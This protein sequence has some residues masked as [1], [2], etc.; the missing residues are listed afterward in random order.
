MRVLVID[1]DPI[2]IYLWRRRFKDA[3]I[4]WD[5]T[6][7]SG[8]LNVKS[9]PDYFDHVFIDYMGTHMQSTVTKAIKKYELEHDNIIIMSN[10]IMPRNDVNYKFMLKDEVLEWMTRLLSF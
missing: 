1:D 8:A 7:A 4:H 9:N 6:I 5:R 3:D 10:A 2:E